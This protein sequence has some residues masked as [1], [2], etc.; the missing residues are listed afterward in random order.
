M[1]YWIWNSGHY[2]GQCCLTA[3]AQEGQ[4]LCHKVIDEYYKIHGGAETA[5]MNE[6]MGLQ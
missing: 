2:V 6:G 1:E 5:S 3:S 4:K